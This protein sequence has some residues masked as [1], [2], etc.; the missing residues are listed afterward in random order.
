MTARTINVRLTYGVGM[1]DPP[2]LS[3]AWRNSRSPQVFPNTVTCTQ[4]FWI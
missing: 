2:G 3:L 4:L 1:T